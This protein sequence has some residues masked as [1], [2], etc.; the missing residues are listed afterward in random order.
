MRHPT[1]DIIDA[2]FLGRLDAAPV[3]VQPPVADDDPI[4]ETHGPAEPPFVNRSFVEPGSPL[5]RLLRTV[6]DQWDAVADR[7]EAAAAAGRR[8][9][10][11]VGG[12][13]G[14]GRSTVVAGTAATLAARGRSVR[15][16]APAELAMLS[17]GER[18][19]ITLVDAG[20]WFAAGPLRMER[21]ASLAQGYD[22]VIF[23]RRAADPPCPAVGDALARLGVSCLGE[24]E[25]FSAP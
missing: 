18:N 20:I 23:V 17:W 19:I 3:V 21:V 8:V 25:T 2:A 10:A 7:I 22:A 15:C 1:V 9:I 16:V 13:R 24:V 5:D 11:V 6:P 4:H 12:R 14:E